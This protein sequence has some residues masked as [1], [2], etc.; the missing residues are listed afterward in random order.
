MNMPPAG[1]QTAA[2]TGRLVDSDRLRRAVTG[3]A[4]G[5]HLCLIYESQ[6][7]QFAVMGLFVR[8]GLERGERCIYIADE[9]TAESVV[10]ALRAG[11]ADVDKALASGALSVIT[12]RDAY[13][14]EGRFD[15]DLMIAFLGETVDEAVKAGYPAVRI[16]GEMTWALGTEPGVDRLLEYESKLNRFFPGS[17]AL[18]MCQYNRKKFPAATIKGVIET[19]PIVILR[20]QVAENSYY[21]P[22]DEYLGPDPEAKEVERLFSRILAQEITARRLREQ[23]NYARGLIESSIDALVTTDSLGILTDVNQQTCEMTGYSRQELIGTPFKDYFTDPAR[24]QDGIRQVLTEERVTNFELTL[25]SRDGSETAVSF[26]ATTF[27]G[28]DGKLKGVFA[29]ARDITAQR[30][31]EDQIRRRNQELLEATALLNSILESSTQ[32]S[33]LAEDIDGRILTWNAGAGSIYG[34]SPEE[35]IGMSSQVLH[36]PEDIASGRVQAFYDNTLKYGVAEGVFKRVRKSGERFTAA[37]TKTLRRDVSGRPIGY[38]GISTDITER[39]V[40]EE[41][42]RQMEQA[43][44][45]KNEFVANM[46]HELRSPL[47]TIMGFSELMAE[48]RAGP[49]SPEHAANMRRILRSSAHLLALINDILDLAK[50]ESGKQEFYPEPVDL[51][52]VVREVVEGFSTM[53]TDKS[54]RVETDVEPDCAVVTTDSSKLKQVL[55]NYL[56][57]AIKF[58][59]AGGRIWVRAANEGE[60]AFRL[61]VEDSGI[62]IRPE[63]MGKLFGE[64][65]QLESGATKRYAG[66]GLGLALTKKMVEAQG[67]SVGARSTFGKG[68]T[69]FAVLPDSS[70]A[71]KPRR[72]ASAPPRSRKQ[73]ESSPRAK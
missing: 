67:G 7:E 73:A 62:G 66:T 60:S 41:Q 21:I 71:G 17:R 36:T 49:I 26:N 19:H 33:I 24:A 42:Y 2:K 22:P 16:S 38:V 14:R 54:L 64:F 18:A 47:T 12:K 3:L 5:D 32:Y 8:T 11:G 53:T 6:A 57:N 20:E 44:R 70:K 48:G 4:P 50:V 37:V 13:L 9:N 43:N 65:Q 10:D 69:F 27:R 58:T 28:E 45:L 35:A 29:D 63:D 15:P 51:A 52:A 31:L 55:Y 39:I 30:A 34:Y 23:Q 25:R 68:S 72:P 61:E 46:S 1:E 59:P 40:L 56:S